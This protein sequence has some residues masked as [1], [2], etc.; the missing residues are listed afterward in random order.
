[1]NKKRM[2]FCLCFQQKSR[3]LAKLVGSIIYLISPVDLM[4]EVVL[5]PIGLLDDIAVLIFI[6]ELLLN[7]LPKKSDHCLRNY[8]EGYSRPNSKNTF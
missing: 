8:E 2:M 3:I 5:G 4:P 7:Q 6:I 1:M